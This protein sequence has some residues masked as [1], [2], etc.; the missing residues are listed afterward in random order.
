[1]DNYHIPLQMIISLTHFSFPSL[2]LT[3]SLPLSLTFNSPLS[4]SLSLLN[5]L[6]LLLACQFKIYNSAI[7]INIKS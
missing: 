5:S 4:L 2:S 1:M 3:C 6:S 7:N